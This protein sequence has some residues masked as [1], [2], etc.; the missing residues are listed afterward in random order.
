MTNSLLPRLY[1]R[2]GEVSFD[3]YCN[4]PNWIHQSHPLFTVIGWWCRG[5]KLILHLIFNLHE[6]TTVTFVYTIGSSTM[7][8][9]VERH[10]I[11]ICTK[12]GNAAGFL[13]RL[14]LSTFVLKWHF[15]RTTL[16]QARGRCIMTNPVFNRSCSVCRAE[17]SYGRVFRR[18]FMW[19]IVILKYAGP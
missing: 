17:T 8:T 7:N 14:Q 16:F 1:V 11:P 9:L 6:T 3:N 12:V 15:V 4:F 10:V 13:P 5:E 19:L 2:I 18:H